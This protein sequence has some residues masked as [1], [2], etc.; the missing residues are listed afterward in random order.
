VSVSMPSV[1]YVGLAVTSHDATTINTSRFD[2]LHASTLED[3]GPPPPW[4]SQ[5]IGDIG[6]RGYT[7]NHGLDNI[8][9]S[10]AGADIWGTSDALPHVI[11]D[12]KPDGGIEFMTR[13][14]SGEATSFIDR[15][16]WFE[17]GQEHPA[18][19]RHLYFP[20]CFAMT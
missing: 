2:E 6:Q 8:Y 15:Q 10:G 1:V 4:M 17:N 3:E 16:R 5:D 20:A 7:Y 13:R 14:A 11:L 18:R 12:V 19:L 9:P